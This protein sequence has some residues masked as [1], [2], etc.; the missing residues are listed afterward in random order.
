MKQ[1]MC[2][3]LDEICQK[4]HQNQLCNN[5]PWCDI[6]CRPIGDSKKAYEIGKQIDHYLRKGI[7][8]NEWKEEEVEEHVK[9][10][11]PKIFAEG[12]LIFPP[13]IQYFQPKKEKAYG[14]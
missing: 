6:I 13:G 4:K 3:V 8:D 5:G 10:I 7:V 12:W 14:Y 1:T 2:P 11:Q 9:E